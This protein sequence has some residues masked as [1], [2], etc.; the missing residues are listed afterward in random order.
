ME[1]P[2]GPLP[3]DRTYPSLQFNSAYRPCSE[4]IRDIDGLKGYQE[5]TAACAASLAIAV[6]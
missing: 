2:I 3:L 5:N 6:D 1:K 4:D